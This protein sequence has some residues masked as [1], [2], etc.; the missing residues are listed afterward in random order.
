LLLVDAYSIAAAGQN[1]EALA[2]PMVMA[3][4]VRPSTSFLSLKFVDA[5]HKAGHDDAETVS[6]RQKS[7]HLRAHACAP[8]CS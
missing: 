7:A 4:R 5:R 1:V 6:A 3:G 2:T 8:P